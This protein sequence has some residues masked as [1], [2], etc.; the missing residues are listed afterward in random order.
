MTIP[1][2]TAALEFPPAD[3]WTTYDLD[4]LP[5]DG[6]RREL[7]DGVLHMPPTPAWFHQ[8]FA[9][10]LMVRLHATCPPE[11]RVTQAVEIRMST[12][13]SLIADVLAVTANDAAQRTHWFRPD[14]VLLAIE[15]VSP[16]SISMDRITKPALYA[17]AGIP[18]YWRI[19]T[20]DAVVVH[21][22]KLDIT[23][24]VYRETGSHHKTIETDEPWPLSIPIA[25]ISPA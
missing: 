21:T 9:A 2:M 1:I 22:H 17:E 15:I 19:E 23:A 11:Y 8:S 5:S 16:T 4:E 7:I 18:Y 24:G 13:R 14:Q 10:I 25:E 12:R 3:G 6:H 20:S